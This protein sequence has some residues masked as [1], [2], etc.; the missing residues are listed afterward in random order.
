MTRMIAALSGFLTE[1]AAIMEHGRTGRPPAR[2]R[3][4]GSNDSGSDACTPGM[5]H[6]N[7]THGSRVLR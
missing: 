2:R 4:H 5:T 7:K 1:F 3:L 6:M